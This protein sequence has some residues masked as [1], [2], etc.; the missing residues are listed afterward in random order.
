[1]SIFRLS[2][3][4]SLGTLCSRFLGLARDIVFT[5]FLAVPV[6]DAF[7]VAMRIPNLFRAFFG[8][9]NFAVSFLPFYIQKSDSI[10]A[11][12]VLSN[13]VFSFLMLFSSFVVLFLSIYMPQ[14]LSFLLKESST[15]LVNFQNIIYLS[16][17]FLFYIFFLLS[18][19]HF[20]AL[21]QV[22]NKFFLAALA[23][24]LLNVSLIVFSIFYH[25][26]GKHLNY[27]IAGVLVGGAL[28]L[29]LVFFS[30]WK[31]KSLPKLTW[32]WRNSGL[33]KVLFKML[34]GFL[35]IFFYQCI[36]LFNVYFSSSLPSGSL[37]SLYLS[38]RIFQLPFSL[39]AI[40]MGTALLPTLSSFWAKKEFYQFKKTLQSNLS[41][42]LYLLL[43]GAVG[44]FFLA[45]P[46]LS[47]FFERGAFNKSQILYTVQVLQVLSFSLV[48][49]GLY[50]VLISGFF[51]LGKTHFPAISS[52]IAFVVY[53]GLASSFS[54]QYGVAGLAFAMS[55]ST[56]INFFVACLL[57]N[58]F[59]QKLDVI[60]L[61]K[62]LLYYLIPV[63]LMGIFL[64]Y[65]PTWLQENLSVS[66]LKL[67]QVIL[68]LVSVF[69]G[70]GIYLFFG[71]LL[72]IPENTVVI[73]IFKKKTLL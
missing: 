51:A 33:K 27:L 1:M 7:I 44:L 62:K 2:L 39:I 16:R 38:D 32:R 56:V 6:L 58:F 12:K 40:S 24:A 73:K 8:E 19:V 29:G 68:L 30:V 61:L 71:S 21:L 67:K 34:P 15:N 50:K 35:S 25:L 23:P 43:P 3:F 63:I 42:S 69:G 41:L 4:M 52:A 46:I 53:L 48:F 31:S 49:L 59:V 47:F 9:G 5:A 22:K 36:S 13:A 70:G 10:E 66:S 55:V 14:V 60:A 57:Y 18:F 28:Q 11:Q 64:W 54:S 65:F 45:E 20:S 37:S 17:F 72:S 26:K